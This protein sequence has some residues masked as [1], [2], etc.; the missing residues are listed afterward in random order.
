MSNNL[1]NIEEYDIIEEDEDYQSTEKLI[2]SK[3]N[4]NKFNIDDHN[5]DPYLLSSNQQFFPA[6][7][8]YNVGINSKY[9]LQ[10]L[11]NFD[12]KKQQKVYI[13][14]KMKQKDSWKNSKLI[15]K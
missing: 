12:R 6:L 8:Q 7:K 5:N 4:F 9:Y 14:T 10:T 2:K 3:Q 15:N 13:N 1:I 11:N